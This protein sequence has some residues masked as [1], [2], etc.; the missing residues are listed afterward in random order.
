MPIGGE[1]LHALEGAGDHIIHDLEREGD[2]VEEHELT[3]HDG[4]QIKRCHGPERSN[5]RNPERVIMPAAGCYG[6]HQTSRKDRA[7]RFGQRR[8]QHQQGNQGCAQGLARPMAEGEAQHITEGIG[9]KGEFLATHDCSLVPLSGNRPSKK[10]KEEGTAGNGNGV[11]SDP[12]RSC[13]L[14]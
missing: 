1:A 3:Q 11:K 7:Q 4:A 10:K 9:T 14:W 13:R 5:G 6:I 2:Q 12:V 8:R